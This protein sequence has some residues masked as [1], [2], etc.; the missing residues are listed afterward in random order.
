MN[1]ADGVDLGVLV[2]PRWLV[3]LVVWSAILVSGGRVV[4][5]YAQEKA[6][7]MQEFVT[8]FTTSLL[9]S[10]PT[11]SIAPALPLATP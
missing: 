2:L 6:E 10:L 1:G 3:Q 7:G 4:T 9:A 11:P 5:W 8:T